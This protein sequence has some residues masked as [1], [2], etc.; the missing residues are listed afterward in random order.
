MPACAALRDGE[1]VH[2]GLSVKGGGR[3]GEVHQLQAWECALNEFGHAFAGTDFGE[4]GSLAED[5]GVGDIG[6]DAEDPAGTAQAALVFDLGGVEVVVDLL[7]LERDAVGRGD[8]FEIAA[9]EGVEFAE[10][11]GEVG[12]AIG[13]D[14]V[15]AGVEGKGAE[16]AGEANEVAVDVFGW[17]RRSWR[18]WRRA[19]S[20]EQRAWRNQ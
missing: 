15:A 16:G 8:D 2:V 7:E 18:W 17:L 10:G 11:V 5:D 20:A 9:D 3:N 19:G 1:V 14:L 12:V 4:R 13:G 6:A